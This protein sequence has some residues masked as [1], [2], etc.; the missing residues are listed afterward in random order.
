M[1]SKLLVGSLM[2]FGLGIALNASAA[3]MDC[4]PMCAEP[5][6]VAL[7]VDA[8]G[9]QN[10]V[11]SNGDNQ[12][13]GALTVPTAKACD[14]GLVKQAEELNATV[15]PIREIIGYVRSPQSLAIKLV[16]DYIVTIPA[17]I[18]FAMDPL[19]SIKNIALDEVRTRAKEVIVSG[20]ACE[21]MPANAPVDVAESLDMKYSA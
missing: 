8:T 4:F 2:A 5:A 7:I 9:D 10:P 15:K 3:E 20:F 17:W 16:N 6:K 12:R 11:M 21:P 19:G 18:G 1:K 14:S 13:E